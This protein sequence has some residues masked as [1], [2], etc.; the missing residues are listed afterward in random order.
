[1]TVTRHEIL[2]VTTDGDDPQAVI[3]AMRNLPTD[4]TFVSCESE[5]IGAFAGGVLHTSLTFTFRRE[6][7]D[8]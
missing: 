5:T 6:V 3:E 2:T 8:E 1:M 4:A 7:T